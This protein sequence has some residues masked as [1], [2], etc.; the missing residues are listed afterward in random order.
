MSIYEIPNDVN[1]LFEN[2]EASYRIVDYAP[3]MEMDNIES[4]EFFLNEVGVTEDYIFEC[5]YP[6][7]VILAHPEYSNKICIDSGGLGDFFSHGFDVSICL[8]PNV[9]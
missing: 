2:G 7:Q 4:M 1:E 3:E 8:R 9:T 6:T 5:D